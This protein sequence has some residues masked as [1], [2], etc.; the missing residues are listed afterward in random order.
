MAQTEKSQHLRQ[1]PEAPSASF[2]D[3]EPV[4]AGTAGPLFGDAVWEFL[5]ARRNQSEKNFDL[6]TIPTGWRLT[7]RELCITLAQPDHPAVVAAGVVRRATPANSSTLIG[8][9]THLRTV[10]L[11]A[12]ANGIEAPSD[13]TSDDCLRFHA[14][15]R[16]GSHA[17]GGRPVGP[18]TARRYLDTIWLLHQIHDAL[19]GGG[20]ATDPFGGRSTSIIAGDLPSIENA[21]SPLPF[22]Q[23]SIAISSAW[24][25]IDILG[26]DIVRAERVRR[27]LP[28]DPRGTVSGAL[29]L[30]HAHVETGGRIPLHTGFGRRRQPRGQP[31]YTLLARMLGISGNCFNQASNGYK[32][33]VVAAI[34]AYA[35]QPN[36]GILGGLA[37]STAVVQ[38]G[39]TLVPWAAEMGPG[40]VEHL[41][42]V[43]RAAGY[44]LL[45]AL[46]AMRDSEIQEISAD[47]AGTCDGMPALRSIQRKGRDPDAPL[48]RW[49]LA[50]APVIQTV[51]LLA[52]ISFDPDMVFSR[53]ANKGP[54][55]PNKGIAR[56]VEFVNAEPDKRVGRG[57]AI[58]GASIDPRTTLNQ[59]TL[60]RSFAVYAARY[61]DA[62]LGL[63]IQLGHAALRMTAGYYL[64]SQEQA[65]RLF[66]TDRRIAVNDVVRQ[67]IHGQL[68]SA[69]PGAKAMQAMSASVV[70]DDERAGKL[71]DVL[72]DRYHL[73]SI[74][75]CH[76]QPETAECGTDGP[77]LAEKRC[78][79]LHCSNA[80]VTNRHERVWFTQRERIDSQLERD[81]LHPTLRLQLQQD[82][83]EVHE[84]LIE[85]TRK[86][87]SQNAASD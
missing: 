43:L 3:S 28:K 84:V 29:D 54:Y 26:P 65:S 64:D 59:Q 48:D 62:E 36:V 9:L 24:T 27:S 81:N 1:I 33:E 40:E 45:C 20:L 80:V 52:E 32:P 42:S 87:V 44:V 6:S 83:S 70:N 67:L 75:D 18:S 30:L 49:W 31:N 5:P 68:P 22:E 82:R 55:T 47:A 13:L 78:S 51:N 14:A 25:I 38:V 66:D 73:G 10:A 72:A 63:G 17:P 77:H 85:L 37:K 58:F 16:S 50:P 69:G 79:T 57:G 19:T 34:D 76:Y 60:R 7:A 12:S 35:A 11:W 39:D 46:T 71:L 4:Q 21:T 41:A 56:F 23:W 86:D 53:S 2:E 74:N 61:P 8:T 15:L